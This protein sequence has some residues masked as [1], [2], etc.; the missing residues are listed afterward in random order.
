MNRYGAVGLALALLASFAACS[1][2]GGSDGGDS[3]AT[4]S[5]DG[6][7]LVDRLSDDSFSL[8]TVDLAAVREQLGI[9]P[10]DELEYNEDLL[11]DEI[12]G[13][14]FGLAVVA[15]PYLA[16]GPDVPLADA[17]DPGLVSETANNSVGTGESAVVLRTEQSFDEIAEELE[18]EGYEEEGDLLVAEEGTPFIAYRYVGTDGDVVVL[19]QSEEAAE[20]ALESPDEPL[21]SGAATMLAI[22]EGTARVAIGLDNTLECGEAFAVAVNADPADGEFVAYAGSDADTDDVLP[23]LEEDDD[24]LRDPRVA[25]TGIEPT[26]AEVDGDYVRVTFDYGEPELAVRT[27]LDLLSSELL[28]SSLYDC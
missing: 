4:D 1:D 13:R 28:P 11:E 7:A 5:D 17:I 18:E 12:G 6:T 16:I 10:D 27:P 14:Y 20:D 25:S 9:D 22:V 26:D 2:D 23:A 8:A 15:L 19:A 3:G 21:D 24:E